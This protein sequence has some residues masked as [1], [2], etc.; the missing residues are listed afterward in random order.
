MIFYYGI[1]KNTVIKDRSIHFI[2][3]LF[4]CIGTW[5]AS[6]VLFKVYRY[7]MLYCLNVC[8]VYKCKGCAHT[9]HTSL[10]YV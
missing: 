2:Y 3:L 1:H 4:E 6:K 5:G 9:H 8:H 10:L 7:I